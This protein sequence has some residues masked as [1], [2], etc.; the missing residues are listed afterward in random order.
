MINL[1]SFELYKKTL[2]FINL[3]FSHKKKSVK[4][5][6]SKYL[7]SRINFFFTYLYSKSGLKNVLGVFN[8]IFLSNQVG[9]G[10]SKFFKGGPLKNKLG[11]PVLNE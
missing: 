9:R 3:D 6:N 8:G 10:F 11:N 5:R 2:I 1:Q 7:A 4:K